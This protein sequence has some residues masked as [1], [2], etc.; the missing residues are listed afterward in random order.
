MVK[1]G[2]I[3]I[4]V[5]DDQN[6]ASYKALSNRYLQGLATLF[7]LELNP[8]VVCE[9]N[10]TLLNPDRY[11]HNYLIYEFSNSKKD[12]SV[13][14]LLRSTTEYLQS[15]GVYFDV[16]FETLPYQLSF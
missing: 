6:V 16:Y 4:F 7:D 12:D 13:V 8:T 2:R 5:S 15:L 3:V 9:P 11:C 10:D 14:S 1:I